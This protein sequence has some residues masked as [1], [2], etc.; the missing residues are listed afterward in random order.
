MYEP[1]VTIITA[2]SN[3][4]E[5]GQADDFTLQVNLIDKQ[6]YPYIEHLVVDNAS[7]DGTQDLLK[8]YKNGGY[9]SFYSE[10]D[11][12]K[13]DAYNKALVRAKGKYVSF[14]SCDDFY[15]D[16][17]CVQDIVSIMEQN[18]ADFCFFN[19][20]CCHPDG[21]VFPFTPAVYNAFQVSPFPRQAVFFRR[22]TLEEIKGFDSKFKLLADY[23]LTIRLFLNEYNGIYYPKNVVTYKLGDRVMKH[24]TQVEAESKHIFY[25]N[26]RALHPM[27]DDV[28]D[29]MI[30][31]SEMPRPLLEK[32]AEKFPPD[33]K[34]LFY[35][36]Y[37]EMY[38][39]RTN[40]QKELRAQER[41][42]R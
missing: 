40:A 19:S 16:I 3:I 39:M 23:D 32:L 11:N 24:P 37:E 9:I 42:N 26:Y 17:T 13:F 27:T 35:E 22:E 6:S 4:V 10:P 14:I 33:D 29:R 21:Y 20:Y 15:H 2:T 8:E 30:K 38:N 41:R 12:G 28:L 34:E 7:T 1:D 31:F 5:K 36:M 25:K 18:E